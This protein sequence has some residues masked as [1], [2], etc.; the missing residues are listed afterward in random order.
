MPARPPAFKAPGS[1][2]RKPWATA[3][4]Y[5][6]RRKRGRAGMRERAQVLSEE[7]YCMVCLKAG[8]RV[9][10]DEVDHIRPL[11]WGGSD[12]RSNKQALCIP[13]HAAKS[14]AER[15]EDRRSGS[16]LRT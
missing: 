16:P 7:P 9:A 1:R 5:H 10:S 14:A 2:N 3:L 11:A 6:D 15:A 8:K 12:D 13:C 4:A